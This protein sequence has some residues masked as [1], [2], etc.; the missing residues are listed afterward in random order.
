[1]AA[2]TVSEN[3]T[4]GIAEFAVTGIVSAA[5]IIAIAGERTGFKLAKHLVDMTAAELHLLTVDSLAEN[6]DAFA[7]NDRFGAGDRTAI[8]VSSQTDAAVVK[9]YA[10]VSADLAGSRVGF[11]I[12]SSRDEALAW[13]SEPEP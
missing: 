8:L 1:M 2:I 7:E 9:L 11:K 10:A 3:S 5:E 6:A 12:T 4:A 13:L